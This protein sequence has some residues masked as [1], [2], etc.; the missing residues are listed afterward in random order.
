M[1]AALLKSKDN[2]SLT[3]DYD[4]DKNESLSQ[5]DKKVHSCLAALL[6]ISDNAKQL[7]LNSKS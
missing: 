4:V 6:A 3:A 2:A 1:C 7:A 5:F